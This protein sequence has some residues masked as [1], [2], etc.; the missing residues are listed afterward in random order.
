[1]QYRS[2]LFRLLTAI[3]WAW[4]VP[5]HSQMLTLTHFATPYD[6]PAVHMLGYD[7]VVM[8][9]DPNQ[10]NTWQTT[11]DAAA[12]S[13]LK[14]VIGGFPPPY[15]YNFGSWTISRNGMALLNYLQSRSN[16]VLALYVFNEPYYTN[17]NTA[18]VSPCGYYSATDLRA[19]RLTIQSFWPGVKI[20]HDLGNPQQWAPNGNYAAI[21]PCVGNRYADQTGVADY[22]GIWEY[23]FGPGGAD[24]AGNLSALKGIANFVLNSMQPAQ[25]ISLNQVFSCPTCGPPLVM[26]SHQQVLQ[27]NCAT[28]NLPLAAVDWYA[29]RR[30]IPT[31]TEALADDP[32][33]W[34]LTTPGACAPGMGAD[35]IGVSAASGMPFVAPNSLASGYG[36]NF[37]PSGPQQ[38]SEPLPTAVGGMTLQVVDAAGNNLSA[39]LEYVSANQINFLMPA[40]AA[41]GQAALSWMGAG[42]PVAAGTVLVRNIAP[43]IFTANGSGG[44]VAA[45]QLVRVG[46]DLQQTIAPI[47]QCAGSACSP[48]PIALSQGP[49]YLTLYGTGIR[50]Y[51]S[52]VTCQINGVNVPVLAAGPQGTYEGLDQINLGPLPNLSGSGEANLTLFVDGQP[53]NVVQVSFQ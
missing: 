3:W 11:L 34:P 53:S 14:L 7:G 13:G 30:N 35:I 21:T 44:G 26:P 18:Q 12:A 47:F 15:Q 22:V 17:P 5:A 9:V 49:V 20:Y 33:S 2:I 27:W 4:G 38:V 31:Y 39:P 28:R 52:G 40:Q 48:I 16:L 6:F 19:L 45:A 41:P 42:G 32:W 50:N 8:T 23:P 51:T 24:V 10:P 37:T 36:V 1:M 43:A 29:F 25:P 46:S